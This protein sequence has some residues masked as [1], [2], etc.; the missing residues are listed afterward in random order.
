MDGR[1]PK[2]IIKGKLILLVAAILSYVLYL[3]LPYEDG[4][5]KGLALLLFVAIMWFTEAIHITVTALLIPVIAVAIGM[6]NMTTQTALSAFADPIIFLFFGGFALATALHSQKL[7]KKI[8]MWLIAMSGSN[9]AIATLAIF[10]VTAF[11]SM[12][13]SN[14]ATAAM[15][16]PLALGMLA[17]LDKEKDRS[18]FVFILLGIA[19]SASIGG[20]GSLV[21]SPPN[22]IA[23]RALDMDFAGWMRIGLPMMLVL[24]PLMLLSMFLVLRPKLNRKV[25][26][27]IED[28]PWTPL[29][30]IAMLIFAATALA[31]IFSGRIA[32]LLGITSPDSWIALV[33]AIAVVVSGTATWKQVSE[34]TEWGVLFLFG[35]GLT[36]SALLQSSGT[37]LVLG[38][39][40]A[41]TFGDAHPFVVILVVAI[42]INVL[43]EFTSNTAS[44]ALLVPVFAAIAV[45]MGMPREVMV[46]VI[47]I[48]ASCA[49]MLPVATPPNAIVFGSGLI[50]QREMISVGAVL[51]V[52]CIILITLWAY[53]FLM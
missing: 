2:G 50:K 17:H 49:F 34:N 46:L 5:N 3:A 25:H 6:P 16:L 20:L 18:T 33:A 7:D 44:A 45:E 53:F 30:V 11:L 32:V 40:V 39:Q 23:A 38:Q 13:I 29:R 15:M 41:Q 31:W 8:A 47:G 35:G 37:S 14:T 1:M 21:G 36:L 51:N 4:V 43:T 26:V 22:A 27:E 12:W 10:A 42:F 9:L 28:I 48:G 24:M 52:L 19:Y